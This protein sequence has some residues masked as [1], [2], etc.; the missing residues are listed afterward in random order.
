[1]TWENCIALYSAYDLIQGR[2][3]SI[4][5]HTIKSIV[6]WNVPWIILKDL[7]VFKLCATTGMPFFPIKNQIWN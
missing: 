6:H 7:N 1:L 3:Q 2:I 4:L 5:K